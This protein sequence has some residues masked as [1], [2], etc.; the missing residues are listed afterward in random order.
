M[1]RRIAENGEDAERKAA[2]GTLAATVTM[3][4]ARTQSGG[5]AGRR[6]RARPSR[7]CFALELP[8]KQRMIRDAGTKVELRGRIVRQEGQAESTDPAVEEAFERLGTTWDFFFEVFARNSIDKSGMPIGGH[9]ALPR[10]NYD[11]ALWNGT[12]MVFGDGSGLR[13]TR[14]TQSLTVCAHELS[15]GVIQYDGPLV[16]QGEAGALNES[17]ADVLGA[18]RRAVEA[19][20]ERERGRLAGGPGDPGA[21]RDRQGPP[22]AGGAPARRTTTTSSGRIRSRRT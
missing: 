6:R 16:Y 17:M 21:G 4:S 3:R 1:L 10:R 2:L 22:L 7:A 8:Q 14:L 5:I 13:F 9:R 12:Q 18:T 20:P 19:R 11:N 15:H